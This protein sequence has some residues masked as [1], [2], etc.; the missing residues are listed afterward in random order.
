MLVYN[1]ILV[2]GIAVGYVSWSQDTSSDDQES[3]EMS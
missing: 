2:W 1:F 3:I